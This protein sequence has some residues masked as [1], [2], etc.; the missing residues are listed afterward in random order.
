AQKDTD[1]SLLD[2]RATYLKYVLDDSKA[3]CAEAGSLITSLTSERDMLTS[4]ALS[5]AVDFG[6]QEGLEAGYEH[7]VAGT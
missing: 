4:E 7:G 6:M 2:S 5:H 1:I 3:A